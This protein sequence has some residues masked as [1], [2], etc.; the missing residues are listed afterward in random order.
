MN[1]LLLYALWTAHLLT[2]RQAPAGAQLHIRLTSP[3][4]SY[5]SQVGSAV[6]AVLIAPL[7]VDG[8]TVLPMGATIDGGVVSVK[9]VGFGVVHETAALGLSFNTVTLPSGES[10]PLAARIEQVDN[11]RER[12]ARDGT[13]RG[14]RATGSLC[15]RASGYI[16]AALKWEIHA[17]VAEWFFRA[18]IVQLPEPEI[19]FPPGVEMTLALREPLLVNTPDSDLNARTPALADNERVDLE[20]L[21]DQLPVRAQ[22]MNGRPSDLMNV[23]FIGDREQLARAFEAAGWVE[24]QRVTMRSRI[25]DI[26]AVAERAGYRHAPMSPMFVNDARPGMAWEKG[27]NDLSKRDHIRIWKQPETWR[28]QEIWMGAATRDLNFAYFRPG[29]MLTHRVEKNIDEERDKVVNDLAFASCADAVG[30]LDREQ[31]LREAYNA[32]GDPM[33]TD[34]RVAVV[35]LND[36]R[37]PRFAIESDPVTLA[38]HGGKMQRFARREVLAMRDDLLRTNMYYRIYEGTRMAVEAIVRRYRGRSGGLASA[39]VDGRAGTLASARAATAR[40]PA[41]GLR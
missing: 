40:A 9:R 21:L 6:H 5:A 17:E 41:A 39:R 12:I 7:A 29:Q 38:P 37:E 4:G 2:C 1:S 14:V 33:T 30:W 31:G 16:Q 24:P 25:R 28:G 3:V 36:C 19:Y 18:F 13:I 34:A 23:L 10:I 20:P 27:F 8:R 35:R 22:S 15:Y 26:R 32:T 11:A